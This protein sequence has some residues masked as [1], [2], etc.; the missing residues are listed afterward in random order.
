MHFTAPFRAFPFASL[1]AVDRKR[2]IQS[3]A[4]KLSAQSERVITAST[5]RCL[6]IRRRARAGCSVT[7]TLRRIAYG[8]AP[9][10]RAIDGGFSELD[11]G[12]HNQ[13]LRYDGIPRIEL[14]AGKRTSRDRRTSLTRSPTTDDWNYTGSAV[15]ANRGTT[16]GLGSSRAQMRATTFRTGLKSTNIVS[17]AGKSPDQ[18]RHP[19]SRTSNSRVTSTTAARTF[20]L[21]DGRPTVTGG[22]IQIRVGAGTPFTTARRAAC[23]VPTGLDQP[24]VHQL[25]PAGHVAGGQADD[26]VLAFGTSVSNLSG[27][28]SRRRSRRRISASRVTRVPA[29]GDGT[30]RRDPRATFTW[31]NLAA[32]ASA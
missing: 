15:Y 20:T 24:G 2:T 29:Q 12:G 19:G 5:S 23:C 4:G 18:I 9:G 31:N 3:Y 6:A 16:G 8:G 27:S 1:G 7:T 13:A 25:L 28:R 22:P 21:A 11:Y 30:G 26:Y 32:A 17:G 10:T 14:A